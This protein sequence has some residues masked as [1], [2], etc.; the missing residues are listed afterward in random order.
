MNIENIGNFHLRLKKFKNN[1]FYCI[2]IDSTILHNIILKNTVL[3]WKPESRILKMKHI[4]I[5]IHIVTLSV[6]FGAMLLFFIIYIKNKTELLR[7]YMVFLLLFTIYLIINFF[8]VYNL[9]VINN[10]GPGIYIITNT[11]YFI[12]FVFFIYQIPLFIHELIGVRMSKPENYLFLGMS[13]LT[14]ILLVL[15]FA[16]KAGGREILD[17]MRFELKFVCY[18]MFLIAFLNTILLIWVYRRR[19]QHE[20][21]RKILKT[22]LLICLIFLPAFIADLFVEKF[23]MTLQVLNYG[24]DFEIIFYLVWNVISIVYIIQ[25]LITK[26]TVVPSVRLS[27]DFVRKYSISAKEKEIISLIVKGYNNKLIADCLFIS[28]QTVKNHIYNIYQKASVNSRAELVSL[29]NQYF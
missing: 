24:I 1:Q 12:W 15:P 5:L 14:I 18:A 28:S 9:T 8:N 21:N 6:G 23:R 11:F 17:M 2:N 22:I 25:Y 29:L 10:P 27:E 20:I 13:V 19:I 16:V 26:I 4:I 7:R 3:S